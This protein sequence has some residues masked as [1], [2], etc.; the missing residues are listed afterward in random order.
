MLTS[1]CWL[2]PQAC[3]ILLCSRP[4]RCTNS[5]ALQEVFMNAS[6]RTW[7]ITVVVRHYEEK[8]LW[9]SPWLG[10]NVVKAA[11]SCSPI[12]TASNVRILHDLHSGMY[13]YNAVGQIPTQPQAI[14]PIVKKTQLGR[15]KQI[16]E[17]FVS[18]LGNYMDINRFQLQPR[19]R[20]DATGNAMA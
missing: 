5:L 8:T 11:A 3:V 19:V 4:W 14:H 12:Q 2:G 6:P 15:T 20:V 13:L 16:I 18:P 9:H 17:T 10:C 7:P 1:A